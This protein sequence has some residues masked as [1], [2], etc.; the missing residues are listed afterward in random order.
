[1]AWIKR[2]DDIRKEARRWQLCWRDSNGKRHFEYFGTEREAKGRKAELEDREIN[3][4]EQF[5]PSTVTL[6]EY[7]DLEG[8][9][10]WFTVTVPSGVILLIRLPAMF[11]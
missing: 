4:G 2:R 9:N 3:R 10:G 1:M 5:T 11:D 6:R 7:I 8:D